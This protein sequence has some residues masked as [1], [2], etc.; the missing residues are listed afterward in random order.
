ML[1]F[2]LTSGRAQ[3]G[4]ALFPKNFD[5]VHISGNRRTHVTH[6]QSYSCRRHFVRRPCR[7][8]WRR[9]T[10]RKRDAMFQRHPPYRPC[11]C[12]QGPYQ[13]AD[14]SFVLRGK[15]RNL[16]RLGSCLMVGVGVNFCRAPWLANRYKKHAAT[17]RTVG[18]VHRLS[19]RLLSFADFFPNTLV[20]CFSWSPRTPCARMGCVCTIDS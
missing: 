4:F 16:W 3:A 5:D 10:G 1:E 19:L 12:R 18:V 13:A 17:T 15:T 7:H 6:T 11:S 9:K 2:K 14:L 20:I 8:Y